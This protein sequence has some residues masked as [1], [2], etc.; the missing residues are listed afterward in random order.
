M[1]EKKYTFLDLKAVNAPYRDDIAQAMMRVLD[2]GWYIGG[3]ELEHFEGILAGSAETPHAVGVTNGL[4]ALRLIFRAYIELGRLR[5]GDEVIVPANTYVASVLAVTDNGLVPVFVEPDYDT[6]NMDTS[7]IEAALTPRTR[8]VLTVH[9]Y[10]RICYDERMADLV[11]RNDLLLVEDNAQA[12]G[13]ISSVR[14][15]FGTS[16]SGGLGHAGAFSFYPSKNIGALGDAGAVTTHDADL[17]RAIRAIRN[18]GSLRQ[19]DNIYKGLNC[20]LDP[21]KAAALA[22]KLPDAQTVG[23]MRRERA[24]IYDH[25]ITNPAVIKPAYD[26]TRDHVWHQYVVRVNDRER[27][28]KYLADCGVE[29]AVHY[30]TPPHRQPC[31]REYSGLNLPVTDAIARSVVSLPISQATSTEDIAAIAE[32]IN[33]YD[34]GC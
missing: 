32:I 31:Y 27:F 1:A 8:A 17:A 23:A 22:I 16:I 30:A 11:R 14:G 12:I 9:L 19:Y 25:L 2:S 13:A 6:L 33:A 5:P 20:R 28:R 3:Q 10:G 26:G 15:L 29:T 7:R 24:G 4:D 18:Y 21:M 34:S